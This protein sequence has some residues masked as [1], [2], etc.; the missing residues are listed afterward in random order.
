MKLEAPLIAEIS[1][2]MVEIQNQ[3][4]NLTLQLQDI[5][6]GKEVREEVWCTKCRIEGHSREHCL[7]FAEYLAIG[8]PNPLP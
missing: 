4:P 2:R 5:K 1:A 8:E 3:L 6:N 7:V